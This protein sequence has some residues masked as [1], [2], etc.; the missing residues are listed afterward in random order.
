MIEQMRQFKRLK[1]E[2][3]DIGLRVQEP[4]IKASVDFFVIMLCMYFSLP[5]ET[6]DSLE[7]IEP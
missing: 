1:H 5:Y 6:G 2:W 4:Y 3:I 7:P